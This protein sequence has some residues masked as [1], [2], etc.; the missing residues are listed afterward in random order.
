[1]TKFGLIIVSHVS[2]IADGIHELLK[3]I[4]NNVPITYAGGTD[5][6]DVSFSFEKIN[7]AVADND[8]DEIFAF[9]NLGS[10]KMNL[11]MVIEMSD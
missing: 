1:M 10:A 4:A 7:R 6:S 8:A 3:E 2:S 5:E 11:E 9:Y